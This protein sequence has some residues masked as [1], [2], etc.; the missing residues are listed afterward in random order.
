MNKN[1]EMGGSYE[2]TQSVRTIND[3][4]KFPESVGVKIFVV[5]RDK[6]NDNI[7]YTG[8]I[9]ASK[10]KIDPSAIDVALTSTGKHPFAIDFMKDYCEEE[11]TGLFSFIVDGE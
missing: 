9:V 8:A 7:K 2:S 11:D 4:D 6:C 1:K 3:A 5:F 10:G